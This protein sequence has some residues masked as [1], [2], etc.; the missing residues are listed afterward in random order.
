[1]ENTILLTKN[2][3]SMKPIY[4]KKKGGSVWIRIGGSGSAE[5]P[6]SQSYVQKCGNIEGMHV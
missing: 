6:L 1:M 2:G 5:F 4:L 3:G